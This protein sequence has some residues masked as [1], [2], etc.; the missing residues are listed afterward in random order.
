MKET[1]QEAVV[2]DLFDESV[3]ALVPEVNPLRDLVKAD[4]GASLPDLIKLYQ[5]VEE[6]LIESGGLEVFGDQI[7]KVEEKIERKLDNCKGLI[8]Y[9]KGQVAFLDEKEKIY[10]ARKSGIKSGIEWLRATMKTALLLTGKEKI[11]TM[12]GTYFFTKPRSPFKINPEYL[13]ER[14]AAALKKVGLRTHKVVITIPESQPG[15]E[16]MEQFA[17]DL[18]KTLPGSSW[19]VTEPEY[20]MEEITELATARLQKGRLLPQWLVAADK[21]FTIR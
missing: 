2:V 7:A 20:D 6:A 1:M 13:T 9:W 21:T 15:L 19:S 17:E 16:R 4:K 10:K 12:E 5:E 8:D 11:K 18:C 14:N 3:P